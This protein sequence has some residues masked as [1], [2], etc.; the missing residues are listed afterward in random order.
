MLLDSRAGDLSCR[1][2][3]A[4][5]IAILHR[6]LRHSCTAWSRGLAPGLGGAQGRRRVQES[7]TVSVQ[8]NAGRSRA[9]GS[10]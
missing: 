2:S 1:K 5:L 3:D 4:G 8:V 10:L 9:N 7:V 6:D